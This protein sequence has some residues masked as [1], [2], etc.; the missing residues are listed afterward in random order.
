MTILHS[1]LKLPEGT[2]NLNFS[3]NKSNSPQNY[4]D[5]AR[6]SSQETRTIF[7]R[8]VSLWPRRSICS[9]GALMSWDT[10]DK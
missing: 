9:P 10:F 7:K 2:W 8:T 3:R 1:Y 5:T 4:A 6:V